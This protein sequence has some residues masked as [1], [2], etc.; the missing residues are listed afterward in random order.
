MQTYDIQEATTAEKLETISEH[1]DALTAQIDALDAQIANLDEAGVCTGTDY[2]REGTKLYANHGIDQGCPIHG[3]PES[4]KRLR[5]YVGTN[6]EAQQETL[7]AIARYRQKADLESQIRQIEMQRG[8]VERSIADAW[9]AA[10]GA[11][12]WEL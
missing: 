3:E 9:H 12:R 7:A 6:Q 11:Q 1:L 5:V 10:S 2:W 4:G 8:R